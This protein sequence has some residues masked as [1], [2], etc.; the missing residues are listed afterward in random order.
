MLNTSGIN[1]ESNKA[2]KSSNQLGILSTAI[3]KIGSLDHSLNKNMKPSNTTNTS[4]VRMRLFR[5]SPERKTKG[6]EG[7]VVGEY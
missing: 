6:L 1:I 5:E 2:Y 3:S 7:L 4:P